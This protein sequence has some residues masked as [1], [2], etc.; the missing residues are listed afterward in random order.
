MAARAKSRMAAILTGVVLIAAGGSVLGLAAAAQQ[1]APQPG[2][3]Q[4]GSVGPVV[5]SPTGSREQA[6]S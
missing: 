2:P 3:A 6:A 1:R 4:A 5:P